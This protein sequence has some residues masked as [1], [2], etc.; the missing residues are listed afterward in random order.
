M[1]G[2][3]WFA[4]FSPRVESYTMGVEPLPAW[5]PRPDGEPSVVVT[6]L[7]PPDSS[8]E[9]GRVSSQA[10]AMLRTVRSWR[11]E[12]LSSTGR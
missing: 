2:T 11:P 1:Q 9:T 3:T 12:R 10:I 4:L 8:I 5:A 7:S 6:T